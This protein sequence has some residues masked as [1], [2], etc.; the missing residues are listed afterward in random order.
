MYSLRSVA[1]RAA[2]RWQSAATAAFIRPTNPRPWGGGRVGGGDFV[3]EWGSTGPWEW[4]GEGVGGGQKGE[5][6]GL[7]PAVSP[8]HL[9]RMERIDRGVWGG[10]SVGGVR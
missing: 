9:Q 5:W 6:A 10:G 7:H 2:R 4:G 1:L 3:G 8:P